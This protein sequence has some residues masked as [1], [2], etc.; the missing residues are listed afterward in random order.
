MSRVFSSAPTAN[1]WPPLSRLA[2]RGNLLGV[3]PNLSLP[4]PGKH[5]LVSLLAGLLSGATAMLAADVDK[6]KLP[7]AASRPVD[8]TKDI[9]P[10]F[11]S[12]CYSCHG[13][14]KQKGQL[15]LDRKADALKGG[16]SHAPDIIPGKSADSPLIHFVAGLV[17]DM[18]MP[19]KGEPL[20]SGQI[21]LLRAWID[22]GAQWPDDG[23]GVSA[24]HWA[25]EPVKRPAVPSVGDDVRSLISPAAKSQRLLTSSP[26]QNP[27]DRFL[28]AKLA[29]KGL[30]FSPSADAR[31]LVRRLYFTT[32]GLPPTPEEVAAF[33]REF[34]TGNRQSA[35]GNLVDKLLTSPHFGER[36]ARHWL[37]VVRFA[38][39]NGYE[40]NGTR[41]N[42]WPYRDWVIRAFNSDMPY[43]RFIA[44]Q[45]AGDALGVEE[46]TG[47]IVGGPTD[48][49]KSPDPVLTAN[50]R[51][52]DLNDF[53]ATTASAFLG[54]T[55]HCARCHNHKF[56][57][58]ATTDYYAVVACFAG[59]Q[60]GE[61]AVKPA[62]AAELTA[63]ADALR[64]QLAVVTRQLERFEPVAR[65]GTNA[66]ARLRPPVTRG[67]NL[68]RF[69]PVA[70]KFLRFTIAET[71]QL[72]PCIDELEAFTVGTGSRNVAL[73]GAGA[74]ATAS[75]TLPGYAIHKLAH[76]NDG[77]Y[78]NDRSWISNER[79]K[80][81]VQIEFAKTETID[82][83]QWSRDRD[84]VPR[85]NDRLATR[86]R[87]EVSRDGAAWQTVA[88]S[89]D[90]Q[91]FGGKAPG[92]VT[93]SAE[94]MAPAEA[95]RLAEL[96][97]SR[98]KLEA[99][100]AAV[101]TFPMIYAGKF[102]KPGDTFRMHRGDPMQ[103]REKVGPGALASFGPK[104]SLP[105]EAPDQERR[106]ALAKWLG[107]PE[108]PLTAR[109]IV[110]RLW[111]YH[112]GTGL[113]DTPSDFGLNGGRPSHPELLDWLAS[114]LVASGW[115]LKHIHRLIL[116]SGAFAQ[117]GSA[118]ALRFTAYETGKRNSVK[119]KESGAD[120]RLVDSSN[121]LLWHFPARR[122]EAEPLRDAMLAV[123]GKLDRTM[124]G[125]G[126][127]LFEANSNYVKVYNSRA[128]FGPAESRR[129]VYQSKPR[130]E[131]DSTFGAFDCPDAGQVSPKRTSST[132][133]LQ[134]LNL[135]NSP[136][137]VQQAQFFA[138]RVE[139]EAG[140]AK[141]AQVKRA[142]HLIFL[143]EPVKEELVASVKL[144]ESHGLP[145]LCRAL[146]NANE[147]LT[148]F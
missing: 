108:N 69:A 43:D 146:F 134:A 129:M 111:H 37:D 19:P 34:Q 28:L 116:T 41:K 40:T 7:S 67:L 35:I 138:E 47:F 79:G 1:R 145:S 78:G 101:T 104:L 8:F 97:A 27:I 59:V 133:P 55:L 88:T 80:G 17:P 58:I 89:D 136:F 135:L 147:F 50:Q 4:R 130:T 60:H 122:M 121:R 65:T 30:M 64:A 117:A 125:P 46:A 21:G 96:L 86:Y 39:S 51:A 144:V 62:N 139:R 74:K 73:A 38:E 141:D 105:A 107:S 77:L 119:R 48:V 87:I 54:L 98:K 26:T 124:G 142:F 112:F 140:Q 36:W 16:D 42:A 25:W 5:R 91:A 113:V 83:V 123:S 128:D 32:I 131:L 52:E 99:D 81:W 6:S 31:T 71:T 56:D 84:N 20:S 33:E 24:K 143:R 63:K 92:G 11:E 22:Q 126:F 53:A 18:K 49:V 127:D 90:R 93:Y 61:R 137:A 109:V 9:K 132:T 148:V 66:S 120:P 114:E 3:T 13:P 94:G 29:E 45:L 110:N 100:I 15:R 103:P 14:D 82:R 76:V 85:Y 106:L 23:S 10:L 115:K 95:A 68:E 72:E 70:A 57:P 2:A 12:K 44:E 75:S 118:Y 102:V